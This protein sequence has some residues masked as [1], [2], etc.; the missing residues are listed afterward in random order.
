MAR[1]KFMCLQKNLW[2]ICLV[3][4]NFFPVLRNF[5]FWP[6]ED[7]TNA[8]RSVG[9]LTLCFLVGYLLKTAAFLFFRKTALHATNS[10]TLQPFFLM[11]FL[12]L[13]AAELIKLLEDS[14]FF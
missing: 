3:S 14:S 12:F 13:P 5:V 9:T 11:H 6:C 2:H 8:W 7:F 4:L 1:Q 10:K